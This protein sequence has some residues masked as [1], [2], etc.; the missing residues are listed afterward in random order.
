[1]TIKPLIRIL[2]TAL[3]NHGDVEVRLNNDFMPIGITGYIDPNNHELELS[4]WT[5]KYLNGIQ[6]PFVI[7]KPVVNE[8]DKKNKHTR[9]GKYISPDT[10]EQLTLNIDEYLEQIQ[11]GKIG[12]DVIHNWMKTIRE[13]LHDN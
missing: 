9:Y 3:E 11:D 13:R 4:D 2:R 10:L 1:M 6:K 5:K 7:I 12:F 8:Y